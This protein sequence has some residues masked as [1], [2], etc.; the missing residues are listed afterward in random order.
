MRDLITT[1]SLLK[2]KLLQKTIILK[3]QHITRE[4]RFDNKG[5]NIALRKK[6]IFVIPDKFVINQK[7]NTSDFKTSYQTFNTM[8]ILSVARPIRQ[9][10][11]S[12]DYILRTTDR[13][14]LSKTTSFKHLLI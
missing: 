12:F 1:E 3:L 8:T 7:H 9:K 2:N 6:I 4:L 11:T 10:T 5:L 14:Y 13:I